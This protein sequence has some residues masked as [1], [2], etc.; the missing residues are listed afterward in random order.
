MEFK[1]NIFALG[2]SKTFT[3]TAYLKL[4]GFSTLMSN[5]IGKESVQA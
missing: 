3:Y 5:N 4:F 1:K 2:V